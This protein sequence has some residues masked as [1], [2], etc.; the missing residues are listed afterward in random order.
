M[1][2]TV[3]RAVWSGLASI[4]TFLSMAATP[5]GAEEITFRV[6]VPSGTTGTVYIAGDFQGWNPGDPAYAL[7][8]IEPGVWQIQLDLP[9]ATPIEFKFTRGDWGTVEKGPSGEELANRQYTPSGPATLDLTVAR[10]ADGQ[11]S[12]ITGDVTRV[13]FPQFLNGRG[14]WVYLPP[15]YHDTT[16]TY[17][18]LYM[19]DGPNLFDDATSFAGEWG[20]DETLEALIAAGEVEPIIVVGIENSAARISEYTPWPSPGFGGGG[21]HAYLDAI[22]TDLLPAVS[23]AFRVKTGPE[24]TLIAGSSLGGLI[25]A[26][27]AYEFDDVFGRVG[28][29]SPSYWWASGQMISH[30]QQRGAP[31]NLDRF[32]Q[33]MGTNESGSAI[34]NLRA[35]RDV[36][37]GQGYVLGDDLAH[38][39]AAGHQHNEF[40]WS[41]RLPGMLRF[42]LAP[43]CAVDLNGDGVQDNGD[44][45]AFVTLFLA[46]DP[47]ADF[48]A[49]GVL[50]NGD[51]GAFVAAFIAG[52]D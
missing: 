32:Y 2:G 25:S 7:A 46:S 49:D 15:G 51:I 44:I 9:S 31:A 45:G 35:M 8:E 50:D 34:P 47:A 52:C 14:V 3:R 24:H 28:A 16:R 4:A 22:K 21:G 5:A 43:P 19:H 6:G 1:I 30:A 29:V 48:N 23:S 20:V 37:L 41:I 33:D 12:T 26:Y 17:P 36:L 39:E 40:Y 27:A 13:T 42:L 38:V 10:W 11:Q 18:V